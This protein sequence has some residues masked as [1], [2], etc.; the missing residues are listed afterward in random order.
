VNGSD[1]IAERLL[2]VRARIA[3]AAKRSGRPPG[4]IALIGV[5]KTVPAARIQE[6]VSAG[7]TDIGENRVQEA[8]EKI[9]AVRPARA[10]LAWHLVGHL[11]QN[12][13]RKAAALFSWI[14]SVDSPSLAAKLDRT[15]GDLGVRPVVLIEVNIAGEV[16][17]HGVAP[18]ALGLLLQALSEMSHL[19]VGG[20]MAVPPLPPP[21]SSGE[22]SRAH[23][24]A[25]A[26]LRDTWRERGY[27]LP[28]LS[29]G[30]TDDYAVA[31]EEGATHVRVGRAIFGERPDPP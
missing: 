31:V 28:A 8:E 29:M 20:L 22:A 14:H 3:E 18:G 6:A 11:Q 5:T 19:R 12:K 13:A 16:T 27:D 2:S 30:M 7:L 21:G 23:F 1:S 26:A 17:K 10:P 4:D 25:L 9:H 24:R 15:A